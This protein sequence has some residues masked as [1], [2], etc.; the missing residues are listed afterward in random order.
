MK[1]QMSYAD[2]LN[3]PYVVIIGDDEMKNE[4]Y[5]LKNMKTGEQ[6]KLNIQ[7]VINEVNA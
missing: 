6:Q 1:K 7:G 4:L 3:I 5:S 2:K